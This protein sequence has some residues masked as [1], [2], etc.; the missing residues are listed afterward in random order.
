MSRY[1]NAISF[2]S[3]IDLRTKNAGNSMTNKESTVVTLK[4]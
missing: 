1:V 4:G 3:Q 2:K